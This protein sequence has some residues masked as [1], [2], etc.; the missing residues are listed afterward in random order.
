MTP[1]GSLASSTPVP[2]RTKLGSYIHNIMQLGVRINYPLLRLR[3]VKL[4]QDWGFEYLK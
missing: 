1:V 4:F 2:S 3:D